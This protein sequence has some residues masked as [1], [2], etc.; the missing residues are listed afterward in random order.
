MDIYIFRDN[1][2]IGASLNKN[3]EPRDR[4]GYW[5]GVADIG[6]FF[7]F[8]I[9]IY[10]FNLSIIFIASFVSFVV[11]LGLIIG[12]TLGLI[13]KRSDH[14][15]VPW[16]FWK[17]V[18]VIIMAFYLAVFSDLLLFQLLGL[19]FDAFS[20]QFLFIYRNMFA[21]LSICTLVIF[22]GF[23]LLRVR[24]RGS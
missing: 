1:S 11:A 7:C 2:S 23:K 18:K 13:L 4:E 10:Q 17:K 9:L 12:L 6:S 8:S 5:T 24:S 14:K 20:Y 19:S 3:N 22:E 16:K 21:I 15:I